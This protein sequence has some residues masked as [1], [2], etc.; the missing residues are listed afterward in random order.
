MTEQITSKTYEGLYRVDNSFSNGL[1]NLEDH[2]DFT[3]IR[4]KLPTRRFFIFPKYVNCIPTEMPE[5]FQ[6][7]NPVF[8]FK[9]KEETYRIFKITLEGIISENA[10]IPPAYNSLKSYFQFSYRGIQVLKIIYLEEIL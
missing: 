8:R 1:P 9:N 3:F 6:L 10:F 2:K 4:L 7:P 5:G